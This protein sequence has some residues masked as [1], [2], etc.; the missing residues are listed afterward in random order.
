[1]SGRET[2]K[3]RLGKR[4]MNAVFYIYAS[5]DARLFSAKPTDLFNILQV[6]IKARIGSTLDSRLSSAL[7]SALSL[8]LTLSR[9]INK[10]YAIVIIIC[11][12]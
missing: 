11:V 3:A 9:R 10:A 1:M 2:K 7:R 4:E 6:D 5:S 12:T 8:S